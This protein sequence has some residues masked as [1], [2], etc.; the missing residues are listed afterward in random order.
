[1]LTDCPLTALISDASG[2][3][4]FTCTVAGYASAVISWIDTVTTPVASSA[5]ANGSSYV[6]STNIS[7]LH[8]LTCIV[9]V[10][11]SNVSCPQVTAYAN[12]T[13]NGE[14]AYQSC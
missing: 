7:G 10:T 14:Y 1:M 9:S 3:N 2:A 12:Y 11:V 13:V 5:K 4:V 6:A 8:T